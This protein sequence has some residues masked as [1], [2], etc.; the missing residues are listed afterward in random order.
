MT[1]SHDRSFP[2]RSPDPQPGVT[3][4]LMVCQANRCRSPFAAAIAER[5]ADD[6]LEIHSGGLMAGGF[7]MPSAGIETGATLGI[8]FSSHRSRELDRADLDGF[9]LILTMARAQARELVADNPQLLGRIFTLKQFDRWIADHPKPRRMALGS[10]LDNVAQD[11]PRT[12]FLGDD[13]NDDIAD[14]INSPASGWVQMAR[15]Q[16]LLLGRIVA[17]LGATRV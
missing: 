7:P 13:E 4:V 17:A 12:D 16:T 14:P 11:R 2:M 3:H 9:D 5:L 15:E 8:D 10:W 1:A 6:S